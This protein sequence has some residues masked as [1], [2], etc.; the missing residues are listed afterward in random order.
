M[1]KC[2]LYFCWFSQKIILCVSNFFCLIVTSGLLNLRLKFW[3]DFVYQESLFRRF[4]CPLFISFLLF[5][6]PII[7]LTGRPLMP[8]GQHSQPMT[9]HDWP[10][11]G[12]G[13]GQSEFGWHWIRLGLQNH[14]HNGPC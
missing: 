1:I 7:I 5:S 8:V 11:G 2:I 3:M 12:M 6:M 9:P 14:R 13:T 4:F 10:R